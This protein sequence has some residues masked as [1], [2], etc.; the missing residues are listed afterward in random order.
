MN[1]VLKTYDMSQL[2]TDQAEESL[3]FDFWHAHSIW[4][5]DMGWKDARKVDFGAKLPLA[6]S[7]HRTVDRLRRFIASTGLVNAHMGLTSSDVED[8]VRIA[9]MNRA[10]EIIKGEIRKIKWP[11]DPRQVT[12]PIPAFTH[13][14]VAGT[15]GYSFKMAAMFAPLEILLSG[16]PIATAKHLGGPCGDNR[17]LKYLVEHAKLKWVSFPFAYF[18]LTPPINDSPIQSSD[19]LYETDFFNWIATVA[20]SLHKICADY[21][22]YISQGIFSEEH[23]EGY[24]G[25][26]S[27]IRKSNP[28]LLEKVC[29]I[30]RHLS[31]VSSEIWSIMAHNGCERTLDSS[32]QLRHLL[33]RTTHDIMYAL[34]TFNQIKI[35]VAKT[36][37][38]DSN[39]AT[40]LIND[41]FR[42][43]MVKRVLAGQSR[44]EVYESL[45][46]DE[47]PEIPQILTHE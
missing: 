17:E 36:E 10:V 40:G 22:F 35:R 16:S 19:Y 14:Q 42:I 25:S 27:I 12:K 8:N 43:E 34:Q 1:P 13:W 41:E 47:A 15:V 6:G 33:M 45:H 23:S 39:I 3:F 21:R 4:L 2:W 32:W 37:A 18:G 38:G 46:Q 7:K 5:A 31:G 9:M 28:Y 11:A 30:T 20:A 24:R 44:I 26:S 29:S